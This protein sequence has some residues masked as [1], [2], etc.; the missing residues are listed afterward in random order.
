MLI[1]E[2]QS[3]IDQ[4]T[5][6]TPRK[7]KFDMFMSFVNI[8]PLGQR[9]TTFRQMFTYLYNLDKS[10]YVIV[11][12]GTSRSESMNW[13]GD[14]MSTLL[15][16]LF[17]ILFG[18]IVVSI[19][20]DHDAIIHAQSHT[21]SYVNFMEGDSV[22]ILRQLQDHPQL[23]HISLLYL[24][25]FDV[26]WANPH[27]SALHHMKEL[28]SAQPMLKSTSMIVVDDNQM[29]AGKGQYVTEYYRQLG[30][31]PAFDAYQIGFVI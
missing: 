6:T 12:T 5:S 10:D 31:T 13:N 18:G 7:E 19:D 22:Q 28:C 11:E 15:F 14:G 27:P 8:L 9:K 1:P 4:L 29:G 21:S 25:S 26:D 30:I 24:D 20:I 16:D 23:S 17:T 2:I 3:I